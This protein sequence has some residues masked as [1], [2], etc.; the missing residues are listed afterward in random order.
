VRAALLRGRDHLELGAIAAEAEACAAVALSRGGAPKRYAHTD[1]NEDACAFAL[2]PAGALAVVADGHQGA[3]GA[4]RA[5]A[6]LLA[7]PADAWLAAGVDAARWSALATD[8]LRAANDA[9]RTELDLGTR[10]PRTTLA[11]ALV[12]EQKGLVATAAIGDSHIFCVDTR[13][14][15]EVGRGERST[16]LF[17][18]HGPETCESLAAKIHVALTPTRGVRALVLATDGLSEKGIG[19]S[20]PA[21][22][23]AE[24]VAAAADAAPALRALTAARRVVETAQEAQRTQ[25]AGDNVASAVLWLERARS[26]GGE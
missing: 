17:L 23:A 14:A 10:R 11:L 3:E 15:R 16:S 25:H 2:G 18:G 24:A 20:D 13:G 1:P 22:A 5:L 7:G 26:H 12:L 8:A 9:V 19:V 6:C 21:A 4:E